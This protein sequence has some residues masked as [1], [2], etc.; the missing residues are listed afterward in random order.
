MRLQIVLGCFFGAA[1][2]FLYGQCV[3]AAT[4]SVAPPKIFE[5]VLYGDSREQIINITRDTPYGVLVLDVSNE[6]MELIHVPEGQTVIFDEGVTSVDFPVTIDA[7]TA[8]VGDYIG[9]LRFILEQPQTAEKAAAS[10][11]Q[12]SFLVQFT[13]AVKER[14]DPATPLSILEYPKLLSAV[15]VGNLVA[16][17][18]EKEDG[19]H[20]TFH[21]FLFNDD[22]NGL[23]DVTS[24]VNLTNDKYTFYHQFI[25]AVQSVPSHGKSQETSEYVLPKSYPSGQY[26]FT[27]AAGNS[28]ASVNFFVIKRSLWFSIGSAGLSIIF[29]GVALVVFRKIRRNRRKVSR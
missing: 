21:W 7:S 17:Q 20:I 22:A 11:V 25:P 9:S 18:Q 19:I 16:T 10:R 12:I 26:T 6:G 24:E 5:S 13:I 2:I 1:F 15:H 14:P 29:L 23:A 27:V 8:A 28:K 3:H 4:L